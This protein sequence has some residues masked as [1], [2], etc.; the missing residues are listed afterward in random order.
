MIYN[1]D[2]NGY[3]SVALEDIQT[4]FGCDKATVMEA[5]DAAAKSGSPRRWRKGSERVSLYPAAQTPSER[6]GRDDNCPERAGT[7]RKEL[8]SMSYLL[9]FMVEALKPACQRK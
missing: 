3:L 6:T 2:S 9:C 1:L 8:A 7:D 4:A 5:L